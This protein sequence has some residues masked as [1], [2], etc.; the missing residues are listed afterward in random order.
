M[1]SQ[2]EKKSKTKPKASADQ[3]EAASLRDWLGELYKPDTFSEEEIKDLYEAYRYQG[4]DRDEVLK[5]LKDKASDV[6]IASQIIIVCALRGPKSASTTKLRTNRT[7]IDMG[8]MASGQQKTKNISCSRV[9]AATAD[10]AAFLLKRMNVPK[11]LPSHPLPGWLQFPAAGSIK[12]PNQF[13]ELHI[14][15]SKRFSP[16]IGGEFNEQIYSQMVQNAYLDPA[17]KLFEDVII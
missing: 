2:E 4:F 12:M 5:Q 16:L 9:T 3:I 11:R 14:D 6:K 15:F 10:L 7:L 17:L 8:I 1:A 13:R